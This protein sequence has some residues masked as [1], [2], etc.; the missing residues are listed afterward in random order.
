MQFWTEF[1]NDSFGRSFDHFQLFI[2]NTSV[3]SQRSVKLNIFLSLTLLRSTVYNFDLNIIIFLLFSVE[4]PVMIR[5]NKI[6]YLILYLAIIFRWWKQ[7]HASS[8]KWVFK[9][10]HIERFH[11]LQRL[12]NG[13][14][15]LSLNFEINY[16]SQSFY[17]LRSLQSCDASAHR[18]PLSPCPSRRS[19]PL[20]LCSESHWSKRSE[21]W[22]E[23]YP[24]V[25]ERTNHQTNVLGIHQHG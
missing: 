15:K 14:A 12:T 9:L 4:H 7:S 20:D 19:L 8:S 17:I 16:K 3:C 11:W 13:L 23:R 25:E 1:D 6:L 5:N 2:W 21:R 24:P 22:R 10:C 18:P